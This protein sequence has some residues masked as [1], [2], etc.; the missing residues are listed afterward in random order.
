MNKNNNNKNNGCAPK[1]AGRNNKRRNN[2]KR[3]VYTIKVEDKKNMGGEQ[4][5]IDNFNKTFCEIFTRKFSGHF[6]KKVRDEFEKKENHIKQ[7]ITDKLI[8]DDFT[9][10]FTE[11]F[12]KKF[13]GT[14][15]EKF[16]K[17]FTKKYID[18]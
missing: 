14:L 9:E 12:I 1:G 16:T 11:K 5:D 17:K 6:C 13:A 3:N 10:K 2:A 15:S 8:K 18:L 7:K 4:I